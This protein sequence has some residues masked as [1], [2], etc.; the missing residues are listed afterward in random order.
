MNIVGLKYRGGGEGRVECHHHHQD[1]SVS[2]ICPILCAINI[3]LHFWRQENKMICVTPHTCSLSDSDTD[4]ILKYYSNLDTKLMEKY[5]I[6]FRNVFF[7]HFLPFLCF[8]SARYEICLLNLPTQ[9]I[10]K[11][12]WTKTDHKISFEHVITIL[13]SPFSYFQTNK[14]RSKQKIDLSW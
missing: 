1:C 5:I 3:G 7:R 11:I 12:T 2:P 13:E 9:N 4:R 10:F 6:I 14:V 8:S